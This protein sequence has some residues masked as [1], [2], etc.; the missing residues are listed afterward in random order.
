MLMPSAVMLI[1]GGDVFVAVL[2]L[3]LTTHRFSWVSA[4][5]KIAMSIVNDLKKGK[6]V[7]LRVLIDFYQIFKNFSL[8]WEIPM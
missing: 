8:F 1:N 7:L 5:L 6:C 4:I 3:E 2:C